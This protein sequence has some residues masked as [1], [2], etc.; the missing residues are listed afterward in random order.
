MYQHCIHWICFIS[1]VFINYY[2]DLNLNLNNY[3]MFPHVCMDRKAW[4]SK[5]TALAMFKHVLL[6]LTT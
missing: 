6:T 5:T 3:H 2:F 4:R 1:G